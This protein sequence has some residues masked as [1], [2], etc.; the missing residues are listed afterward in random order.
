MTGHAASTPR[1]SAFLLC[2]AVIAA[3]PS[4]YAEAKANLEPFPTF[5]VAAIK[6][7]RS[8][9]SS[10]HTSF[11]NGRFSATNMTVKKMLEYE[12]YDIAEKQIEG[13]PA[14]FGSDR[15]DIEAKTDEDTS[16]RM[17]QLSSDERSELNRQLFQQLLADRFKLAVH[18]G[19]KQLQVYALV[20]GRNGSKLVPAK[21]ADGNTGTSSGNGK[22]TATGITMD[23]LAQTLTSELSR[24]LD[25]M[26]LDQTGIAGST[27]FLLRGLPQIVPGTLRMHRLT[28]VCPPGHPSSQPCRNSLV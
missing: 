4:I 14:W 28:T 18:W 13:G 22:L 17:R 23:K 25:R 5:E 9:S 21:N 27:I 11:N 20:V 7:N 1:I 12:A 6:P 10:S 3:S 15:F 24:E 8:G 26:I 16:Q 2:A 19:T